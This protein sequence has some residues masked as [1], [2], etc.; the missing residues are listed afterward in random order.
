M[1]AR[2]YATTEHAL[3][4]SRWVAVRSRDARADG[5]FVYSVETTGVYC[6]PSCGARPANRENVAFHPDVGAATRAGFRPC[7]RCKPNE[8][9][10][11]ERRAALVAT[12]CRFIESS[13]I[14]PT[15][16]ALAAR[17]GLS[18]FHVH[19]VFKAVTGL[20]PKAYAEAHRAGRARSELGARETVTEAIHGA[21]Y[22]SSARFY[23]NADARLG[24][25]PTAFR[26]GAPDLE[27]RFAIGECSL[28]AILV[29][30][31]ARG[32]CAIS[33]GDDPEELAH[34]LE[35][36]FSRAKIIGADASFEATVAEVVGLVEAPRLG[37]SL[38]LD[39]RGTA[40]QERVW[41]ALRS[42]PAGK[43]VSYTALASTIGAPRGARAVASACAANPLAVAIPC[44]RVVRTDGTLSG[45]RWGVERKRALLARET[46]S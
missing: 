26:A 6:H 10:L 2:T 38:P 25:T 24:M 28:G 13:E 35:R 45:Y 14:A 31:T 19:R 29:A 46:V 17:A 11:G 18:P 8:P 5:T 32:V 37:T 27:I 9:P 1:P 7:K 16:E 40:F 33:I 15:L 43:T 41:K 39:I 42:I 20:S 30:A 21:G 4:E 44:H 12:L 22:A 34:D 36:R 3:E 23:E